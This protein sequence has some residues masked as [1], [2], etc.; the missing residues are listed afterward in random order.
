MIS[1]KQVQS[2]KDAGLSFEQIQDLKI[3]EEE[4]DSTWVSYTLD[5][6][7]VIVRNNIFS[8]HNQECIK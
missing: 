4:F 6:A 1:T 5:E 7:F 3:T 2:L 8:K